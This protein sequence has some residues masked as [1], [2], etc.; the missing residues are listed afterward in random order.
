LLSESTC[1][2]ELGD[3]VPGSPCTSYFV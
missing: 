1:P 3:V 2:G